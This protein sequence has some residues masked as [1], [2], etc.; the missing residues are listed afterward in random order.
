M[1]FFT[2]IAVED[3]KVIWT[4]L[5][6]RIGRDTNMLNKIELFSTLTNVQLRENC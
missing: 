3:Y 1:P 5:R 4:R 6:Q 2:I